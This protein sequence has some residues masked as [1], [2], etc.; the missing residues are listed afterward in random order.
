MAGGGVAGSA[1]EV[2]SRKAG[3]VRWDGSFGAVI[4]AGSVAIRVVEREDAAW[5]RHSQL[6]KVLTTAVGPRGGEKL[7]KNGCTR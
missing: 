7:V 1:V 4:L 5:D 6:Q 3:G 2:G